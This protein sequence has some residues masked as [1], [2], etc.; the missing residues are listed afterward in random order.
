MPEKL[1]TKLQFHL[2]HKQECCLTFCKPLSFLWRKQ[3]TY[4]LYR[5]NL[6]FRSATFRREITW[7][8]C[9]VEQTVIIS[10][11]QTGKLVV[12]L[13]CVLFLSQIMPIQF[14]E[15]LAEELGVQPSF[16][17]LFWQSP[18]VAYKCYYGPALPVTYRLVGPGQ[19]RHQFFHLSCTL[20]KLV[21]RWLCSNLAQIWKKEGLCNCRFTKEKKTLCVILV[22]VIQIIWQAF[23]K[24]KKGQRCLYVSRQC[25]SFFA[26]MCCRFKG[27]SLARLRWGNAKTPLSTQWQRTE[28]WKHVGE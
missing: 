15:E 8:C 23:D 24:S 16:W 10:V 13:K 4:H 20:F 14:Q 12:L 17:K 28:I 27:E 9:L 2:K 3:R 19:Y 18:V 21:L 22:S 7:W 6:F 1:P 5:Y 25:S 11:T 26:N